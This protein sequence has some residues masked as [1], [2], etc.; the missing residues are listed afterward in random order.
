MI[1]AVFLG[2]GAIACPVMRAMETMPEVE[3]LGLVSQPDRPSGRRM[4]IAS[5]PTKALAVELELPVMQ[6]ERLRSDDTCLEW[7]KS[8]QL[9]IA[10]VMAYGQLLS[11]AVLEIPRH[12]CLNLHTSLLPKYRGAAPIQWAIWNGDCVTGVSLMKMDKG[13]DTGPVISTV[14]VPIQSDTSALILHDQLSEAAATLLQSAL[15]DYIAGVM[16]PMPQSSN[17][18]SHA[19]KIEKEDGLMDWSQ[20]AI[21]LDRQVRALWSWP[22]CYTDFEGSSGLRERLKIRAVK[23]STISNA[24]GNPGEILQSDK[25]GLK[26]LTG[27][28]VLEIIE[29]QR[30][31]GRAMPASA[32]LSGSP[33]RVGS[34]LGQG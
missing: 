8:L 3:L 20:P 25:D 10:V 28:G 15:H 5:T 23:L 6:P 13:M 29:I 33:I 2:T 1:R 11:P 18:V 24:R 21:V 34:L 30:Q 27:D 19:R 26:V 12:G 32:F 14:K 9:D 22:G 7:L 16:K 4:K 17:E 31:G